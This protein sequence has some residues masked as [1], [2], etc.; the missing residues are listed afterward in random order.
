MTT[1][2]L[3]LTVATARYVM[4]DLPSGELARR[5]DAL[6]DQRIYSPAGGELATTRNLVMAD[7]GPLFEQAMQD[8]HAEIPSRDNA[9]WILLR[10]H[11]GRIAY[12]DVR[13][14][15]G[16]QFVLDI[17]YRAN[18]QEESRTYAGDSHGIQRLIGAYW[19]YG[20]LDERPV[21]NHLNL[22]R[23]SFKR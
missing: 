15:D 19:E 14:R 2:N 12:E 17:Y 10:H 18:L 8:L 13:P 1:P 23:R 5:A 4:G 6:L 9:V 16:R 21:G 20:D 3:D 7:A 11:I 22:I